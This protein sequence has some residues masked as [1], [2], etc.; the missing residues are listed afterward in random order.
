MIID[1][2]RL[3]LDFS[4]FKNNITIWGFSVRHGDKS[5]VVISFDPWTGQWID[6]S[7]ENDYCH[8]LFELEKQGKY[9]GMYDGEFNIETEGPE[10]LKGKEWLFRK[11]KENRNLHTNERHCTSLESSTRFV[12]RCDTSLIEVP[13]IRVVA[14]LNRIEYGGWTEEQFDAFEW[15]NWQQ[16]LEKWEFEGWTPLDYCPFCGAKLPERLDKKIMEVLESE[17]G[18]K[19]WEDYKKAPHEFHTDEWWRKRGL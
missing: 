1:K 3:R 14:V 9:V 15:R 16:A 17:Y 7:F 4:S 18:L 19:S 10:E 12:S 2:N 11:F 13:N 5:L 8:A 6:A